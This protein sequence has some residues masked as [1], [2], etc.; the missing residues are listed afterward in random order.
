MS[1]PVEEAVRALAE[2]IA[3]D[4]GLEVVEVEFRREQGGWVLRLYLDKPGGVT[5]D[6]C[7]AMSQELSPVLDAEDLIDH[8]Y[9]L[10]VSSPGATRPLKTDRDFERFRGRRVRVATYEK[11][12]GRKTF[13]GRL[14]GHSA[15]AI[16]LEEETIGRVRLPRQAVAKANLELDRTNEA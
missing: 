16:E 10:E 12:A 1:S 8:P 4:L 2:P 7:A 3:A 15:E 11:I 13:I 6:D 9:H 14:A 5:L